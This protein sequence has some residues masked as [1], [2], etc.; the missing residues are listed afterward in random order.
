MQKRYELAQCLLTPQRAK[1][2]LAAWDFREI[3]CGLICWQQ[4]CSC[5]A[6]CIPCRHALLLLWSFCAAVMRDC[7][8]DALASSILAAAAALMRCT[9]HAR[10]SG[11]V[12]VSKF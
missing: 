12:P 10:S 1:L 2:M 4:A 11:S 6:D 9:P 3:L 8:A 5:F 7:G